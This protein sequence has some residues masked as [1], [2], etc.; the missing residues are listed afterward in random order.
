V[1]KMKPEVK[2]LV[3]A[4]LRSGE[5]KQTQATLRRGDGFC[6][7]GVI[8][9]IYRRETGN[10]LWVPLDAPVP[11]DED[12]LAFIADTQHSIRERVFLPT[13]VAEWCGFDTDEPYHSDPVV[14]GFSTTAA[15][16][17]DSGNTFLEIAAVIKENL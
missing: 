12:R 8:C 2:A 10:G 9:E 17:N 5:F 16:M 14:N 13:E 11:G 4:A 3:V 6:C 7:L 1:Q 15:D